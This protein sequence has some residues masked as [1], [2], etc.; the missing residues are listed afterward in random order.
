ME[1][2]VFNET[3]RLIFQQTSQYISPQLSISRRGYFKIFL[4]KPFMREAPCCRLGPAF[5]SFS[6]VI[7][8][9]TLSFVSMHYSLLFSSGLDLTGWEHIWGRKSKLL[10]SIYFLTMLLSET[11]TVED[12]GAFPPCLGLHWY[13]FFTVQWLSTVPLSWQHF[14]FLSKEMEFVC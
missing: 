9:W 2:I 3:T 5:S 14:L 6:G 1:C 12:L 7:S 10:S 11:F 13:W 4:K 8:P